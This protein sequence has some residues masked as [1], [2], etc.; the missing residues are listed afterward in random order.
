M[1]AQQRG[2]VAFVGEGDHA[3]GHV[4][5]PQRGVGGVVRGHARLLSRRADPAREQVQG[6]AHHVE[7]GVAGVGLVEVQGGARERGVVGEAE[8]AREHAHE[9]RAEQGLREVGGETPDYLDPLDGLGWLEAGIAYSRPGSPRRAAQLD[10]MAQWRPVS[11]AEHIDVVE[12]TIDSV[13]AM[14]R[15]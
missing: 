3:A 1:Q 8:A 9:P 11:W 13:G 10:R 4:D 7:Q 6:G 5:G 14:A 2:A 12:A 15:G